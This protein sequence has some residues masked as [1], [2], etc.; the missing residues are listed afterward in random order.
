MRSMLAVVIVLASSA[1]AFATGATISYSTARAI[2]QQKY[3]TAEY[4]KYAAEFVQFNN[5]F[6]LDERD[7]CYALGSGS[8]DLMLF[9]THPAGSQFAV[10]ERV[11]SSVDNA[12]AR[13]FAKSYRGIQTKVPPFLPFVLQMKM[14]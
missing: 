10:V 5:H 9:I 11:L 1:S 6:H 14:R 13:C 4:Q 3:Q 2:W 7:G 8:V 12:K